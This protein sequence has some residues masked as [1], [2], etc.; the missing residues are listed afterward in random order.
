M[1]A[2]RVPGMQQPTPNARLPTER[3]PAGFHLWTNMS[4]KQAWRDFCLRRDA[5]PAPAAPP[6]NG[7]AP[8]P[9]APP[10]AS[11]GALVAD[12]N[13][14]AGLNQIGFQPDQD[15]ME[16]PNLQLHPRSVVRRVAQNGGV[17]GAA[18]GA[19]VADCQAHAE[20]QAGC[21]HAGLN[22]IGPQPN[23]DLMER[24]DLQLHPRSAQSGARAGG[25]PAPP[26][27]RGPRPAPRRRSPTVPRPSV[28][29]P[30]RSPNRTQSIMFRIVWRSPDPASREAYCLTDH[31][32]DAARFE[33]C[34][35]GRQYA[36]PYA[37]EEDGE[38]PYAVWTDPTQLWTIP[39]PFLGAGAGAD[40]R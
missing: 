8:A 33:K 14:H 27:A 12:C 40:G 6:A 29:L 26:A 1:Q 9:P 7:T 2:R 16:R 20:C 31:G 17:R 37:R 22:Q 10:P 25:R 36:L 38:P 28:S 34:R 11:V 3:N 13:A 5:P 4:W 23:Q 30:P 39:R 15:L 18:V 24:P 32:S 21:A 19:L 35:G